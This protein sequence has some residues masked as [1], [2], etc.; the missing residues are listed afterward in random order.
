[1]RTLRAALAVAAALGCA[2]P[3]ARPTAIGTRPPADGE[4]A[5]A[6]RG[7]SCRWWVLGVPLGLPAIDAALADAL[8]QAR[9]PALVDAVVTS[10]HPT[11]GPVGRHCY[12]VEGWAWR[13]PSRDA[14]AES[15]DW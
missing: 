1:M 12:V 6:V 8:R 4:S 14:R 11:Y 10:V 5:D 15:G 2:V 13:A 7:R 9:A 3:V